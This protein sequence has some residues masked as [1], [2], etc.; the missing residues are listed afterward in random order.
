MSH[1]LPFTE[2]FNGPKHL[3]PTFM[4]KCRATLVP[5]W[6]L[7]GAETLTPGCASAAPSGCCNYDPDIGGNHLAEHH[8]IDHLSAQLVRG[9]MVRQPGGDAGKD[10]EENTAA[11]SL[12]GNSPGH[13]IGSDGSQRACQPGSTGMDHASDQCTKCSDLLLTEKHKV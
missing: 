7:C 4:L 3:I 8:H 2:S 1:P 10:P 13:V 12:H 5:D 6:S 9:P 11:Q